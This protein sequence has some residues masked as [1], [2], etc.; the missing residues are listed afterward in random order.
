MSRKLL[1]DT[2]VLL[3]VAMGER[4]GWA[5]ATLLVDEFAY[6]QS[7]GYVS[8]LSLKDVY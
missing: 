7:I 2:N 3:D 6:G 8:A 1:L 4:T 5:V